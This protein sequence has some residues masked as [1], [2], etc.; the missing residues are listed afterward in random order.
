MRDMRD[1]PAKFSTPM[2]PA[3]DAKSCVAGVAEVPSRFIIK[4]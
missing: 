2:L 4:V 1:L 3:E